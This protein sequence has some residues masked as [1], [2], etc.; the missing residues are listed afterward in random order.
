MFVVA[1]DPPRHMEVSHRESQPEGCTACGGRGGRGGGCV[2][3]PGTFPHEKECLCACI[4]FCVSE[5]NCGTDIYVSS[6]AVCS[7]GP[8]F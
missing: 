5:E 6:T 1:R 8:F 7:V 4:C 2:L 3:E